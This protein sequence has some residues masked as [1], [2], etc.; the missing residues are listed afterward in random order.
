MFG[1][2]VGGT[3]VSGA[4]VGVGPLVVDVPAVA[5]GDEAAVEAA[6]EA[7]ALSVTDVGL[8]AVDVPELAQPPIAEAMTRTAGKRMACRFISLLEFA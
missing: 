8:L 1:T 2:V 3:V 5:A 4:V 7:T 6:G